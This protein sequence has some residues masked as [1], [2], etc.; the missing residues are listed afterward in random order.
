MV[1]KY[2]ITDTVDSSVILTAPYIINKALSDN[3]DSIRSYTIAKSLM[4]K[5]H[6]NLF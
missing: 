2:E 5:I 3:C 6:N 1:F 4:Y